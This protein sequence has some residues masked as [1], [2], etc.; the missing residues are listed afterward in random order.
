[1]AD[2]V[3]QSASFY[4]PYLNSIEVEGSEVVA[5]RVLELLDYVTETDGIHGFLVVNKPLTP[6]MVDELQKYL[7]AP[8]ADG[9]RI[10]ERYSEGR[11]NALWGVSPY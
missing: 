4:T 3:F 1:M 7:S 2:L 9:E 11:G 6:E 8:V 5:R 10:E